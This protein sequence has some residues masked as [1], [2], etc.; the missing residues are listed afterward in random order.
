MIISARENAIVKQLRAECAKLD[1]VTETLT[2]GH[3]VFRVGGA[4]GGMFC[5]VGDHKD[6]W[7]IGFNVGKP[8]QIEM[9]R[10]DKKRFF[11][12]PYAARL[13]WV[14]MRLNGRVSWT[15]IRKLLKIAHANTI[16]KKSAR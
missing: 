7:S 10:N 16:E 1:D 15:I 11:P 2:W 5:G 12:T 4:K 3:P 13:G 14:S 6:V 9:L 8:V